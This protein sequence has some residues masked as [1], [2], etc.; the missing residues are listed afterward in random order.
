MSIVYRRIVLKLSGEILA[1]TQGFGICADALSRIVDELV[2]VHSLGV[3]L[4][5]VI[6]GGNIFRGA[7]EVERLSVNRASGDYVG[8]L[9]TLIN[10]L[11]LQDILE[12]RGVMTR[13]MS[14]LDIWELAEPFIRRKALKHLEKGR[15]VLFACGTG[16][17]YFTTDTAAALRAV[18]IGAELLVKGTKVDGVYDKDPVKHPDAVL[19]TELSYMEVLERQLRVMDATA[20][21][22]C[23]EN[24]LPLVVYNVKHEGAL[25]RI[26]M[27]EVVGTKIQ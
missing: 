27:G 7:Y 26:V 16:N 11:V 15:V 3:Q 24:K 1:G 25:K 18:E 5:V 6:G 19:Y 21:S 12:K 9:A 13:V 8:M 17:P 14:A 10:A 22:L 23:M 20:I 4:G 2:D